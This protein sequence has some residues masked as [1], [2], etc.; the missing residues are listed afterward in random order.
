MT[1]GRAASIVIIGVVLL[2]SAATFPL[3]DLILFRAVLL[4]IGIAAI[5]HG[6]ASMLAGGGE[7]GTY[8]SAYAQIK[9]YMAP[10][11]YLLA[12]CVFLYAAHALLQN[13]GPAGAFGLWGTR[14]ITVLLALVG[15]LVIVIAVR[16]QAAMLFGP[17]WCGR[18]Y[19]EARSFFSSGNFYIVVGCIFL[20]QAISRADEAHSSLVFI[21]AILG[22]A[23][24]LYGT[25]TQAAA[26]GDATQTAPGTTAKLNLAIAGGAGVLAAVFGF[27]VLSYHDEI[28]KVFKRTVDFGILELTV[29]DAAN[30]GQYEVQAFLP[31]S[32]PLHTWKSDT[33][34]QVIVPIL[35][36]DQE[37]VVTVKFQPGISSSDRRDLN[38]KID[39]RDYR[40]RWKTAERQFGFNNDVIRIKRET[41][42]RGLFVAPTIPSRNHPDAE[43]S[44]TQRS[45]L[46]PAAVIAPQ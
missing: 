21:L 13:A 10:V 39:P 29:A 37:V 35:S 41:F 7:P 4:L 9:S 27:G 45:N 16:A 46:P 43:I 18:R 32:R 14:A 6:I 26:Q 11:F 23:I 44:D 17:D 38:V 36:V 30:L 40:I 3:L 12:A 5:L 28:G 33:N 24:I 8:Q 31:G 22:V 20:W 25:G 42:P 1:F 34:M 2:I 15:V 19:A